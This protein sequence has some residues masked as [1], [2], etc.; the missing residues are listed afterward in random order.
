MYY[1]VL[2]GVTK[3][4]T[5]RG[6]SM[7]GVQVV[8][9]PIEM[10]TRGQSKLIILLQVAIIFFYHC[11]HVIISMSMDTTPT[12]SIEVSDQK[13]SD[14][15]HQLPH[16]HYNELPLEHHKQFNWMIE[17]I[18]QKC[19]KQDEEFGV[20]NNSSQKTA[21]ITCIE[22]LKFHIDLNLIIVDE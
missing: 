6:S 11:P 1:P 2:L 18:M 17:S 13:I 14:R 8:S 9:T 12:P 19:T 5:K 10:M 15:K 3:R 4:S 22:Q 7:L 20:F 16:A 21:S